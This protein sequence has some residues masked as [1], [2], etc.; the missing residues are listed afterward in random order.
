VAAPARAKAGGAG[1]GQPLPAS[2]AAPG[3]AAPAASGAWSRAAARGGPLLALLA[4]A[5]PTSLALA[6]GP[7][8]AEAAQGPLEQRIPGTLRD[9]FL[10]VVPWDAR[11]PA[12]GRIRLGWSMAND[13]STPTVLGKGSET[14]YLR[15][16]E[17]ADA[18]DLSLR[19]PW[20]ATAPLG[21][22][23]LRR[24][25]S[26]L[27]ARVT[28]HW[29]GWSDGAIQA[30]HSG[31]VFYGFGRRL[32]P[33]DQVHVNLGA[34]GASALADVQATTFAVGDLVLRNQVLLWEGGEPLAPGPA[35]RAGVS[36]RL[37]VKFPTG[38]LARLGGSGGWDVALGASGTWQVAPW[39]VGHATGAVA[40]WSG[41]PGRFPMQPARWHGSLDLSLVFLAGDWSV[42]LEDRLTSPIFEPGWSYVDAGPDGELQ[43]SATYA[44]TRTQNQVTLGVRWGP[45]TL[46]I[47]EDYFL[48]WNPGA[49]PNSWFYNSNAPDLAMGLALTLGL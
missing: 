47:S 40:A 41:L 13:W 2:G 46:W 5:A 3:R 6:P 10:E 4:V 21:P 35:A 27:E 45:L 16:D 29:G 37:D 26:A 43:T 25:S 20:S 19:L 49:G 24:V 31:W 1:T 33:P 39:L 11:A 14:V 12:G 38:S 7:A 15:L 44:A 42:V 48:G 36:L 18:L 30:W 9:L 32:Y 23:W 34:P 8:H 28:W 22:A 17:Q